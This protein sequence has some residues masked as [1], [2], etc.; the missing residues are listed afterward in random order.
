ML[1]LSPVIGD[2]VSKEL[3][4][5]RVWAITGNWWQPARL[6]AFFCF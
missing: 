4:D 3:Q 6:F 1:H 5:G 2:G